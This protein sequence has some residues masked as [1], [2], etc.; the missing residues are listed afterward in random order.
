MAAVLAVVSVLV[1]IAPLDSALIESA[2]LARTLLMTTL[3]ALGLLVDAPVEAALLEVELVNIG[4]AAYSD[5]DSNA[6]SDA[7]FELRSS[8][9]SCCDAD[10]S[11][12][13][14]ASSSRSSRCSVT[15]ASLL[16]VLATAVDLPA[17]NSSAAVPPSP[18]V[19]C[20]LVLQ[21]EAPIDRSWP[22]EVYLLECSITTSGR[23]LL[24]STTETALYTSPARALS[25]AS[26]ANFARSSVVHSDPKRDEKANDSSVSAHSAL[27]R[28][29]LEF[30][31]LLC[32][33]DVACGTCPFNWFDFDPK[34]FQYQRRRRPG[35]DDLSKFAAS[36]A[37]IQEA[38]ETLGI[39][40]Q[41]TNGFN[42]AAAF[43]QQ[44]VKDA[45]RAKALEWHPDCNP[46]PQAE[47]IFKE[48][49]VAYEL[50]L[51]HAR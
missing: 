7:N 12:D 27:Q 39:A 9:M 23:K 40:T 46:D 43:T 41:P 47:T 35:A 10:V 34:K 24:W 11:R 51:A 45:F 25:T 6:D 19:S 37:D 29:Q 38:M 33:W 32:G 3:P 16:L 5:L 42:K 14:R 15:C 48:I 28:Q 26:S 13:E 8:S 50:L 44:Q 1:V 18:A 17:K 21:Q 22:Q 30:C 49:L 36:D 20:E 31:C 2:L 4:S